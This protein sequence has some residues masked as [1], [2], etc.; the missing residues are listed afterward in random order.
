MICCL[1]PDC[2]HPLNPET[3]RHCQQCGTA[4]IPRLRHRYRVVKPLG[5]GGFGKTYLAED[6]DK[7]NEPC[8]VKQFIFSSPDSGTHRKAL[9]LFEQE[10]RQLQDLGE[11][12]QIPTL[13]AYFQEENYFYLV[14]QFIPGTTL[15]KIL[16]EQGPFSDD[17]IAQLLIALLPVLNFIHNQGIIHRDIKPENIIR[18]DP[19]GLPILIDFGVAKLTTPATQNQTGTMLGSQGY[20]PLEQLQGGKASPASDLFSLGMTCFHLMSGVTPFSLWSE[21]G[22]GWLSQWPDFLDRPV[23]PHLKTILDGL[24][25]KE[26]RDRPPSAHTVLTQLQNNSPAP[27]TSHP[28]PPTGSAMTSDPDATRVIATPAGATRQSFRWPLVGIV[29]SLLLLGVGI[30]LKPWQWVKSPPSSPPPTL[31]DPLSPSPVASP[32]PSASAVEPLLEAGLKQFQQGNYPAAINSFNKV[33]ALDPNHAIALSRRGIAT[34]ANGDPQGALMDLN[35]AIALSPDYAGAYYGRGLVQSSLNNRPAALAD[36]N[37]ALSL[38]PKLAAAFL[39]RGDLYVAQQQ[40]PAAIADY[41]RVTELWSRSPEVYRKR[42][43]VYVLLGDRNR[44]M[45]DFVKAGKLYQQQGNTEQV[46]VIR[47]RIQS[48]RNRK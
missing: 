19:D 18:R 26:V 30:S 9:Q 21:Q 15:L 24:L 13:L 12:P 45:A 14:Q 38:N 27:K 31:E 25:Q 35:R 2:E 36:Y 42:A 7:L 29:A 11:H 48:L 8:V 6:L 20:A 23:D 47:D 5:R 32:A 40:Y 43:E 44:A 39:G 4:L 37:R 17:A 22:Y 33:L 46:N 10:A 3:H 1:N 41:T 16:T 28:V 34:L